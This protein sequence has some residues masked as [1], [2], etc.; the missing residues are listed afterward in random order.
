M[1]KDLRV[2]VVDDGPLIAHT[3]SALIQDHGYSASP[4]TDPLKALRDAR[5]FMPDALISDVDMPHLDGVDL[6]IKVLNRCPHCKVILMSGHAGP[7]RYL[8][9]ARAEG[10][11]FPF[12]TKPFSPRMLLEQLDSLCF[13][14]NRAVMG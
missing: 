10:F 13:E 11:D 5:L 9:D 4:Y 2:F 14:H 6:A 12:F 8:E 7:I 1:R 3:L